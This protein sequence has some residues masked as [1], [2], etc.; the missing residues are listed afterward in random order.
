[1]SSDAAHRR[2]IK[3]IL[4]RQVEVDHKAK[5]VSS[6]KRAKPFE[7]AGWKRSISGVQLDVNALAFRTLMECSCVLGLFV[8]M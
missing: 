5:I 2:L 4:K 7:D 1:M 3:V 6:S 8:L